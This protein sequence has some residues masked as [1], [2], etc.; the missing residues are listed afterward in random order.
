MIEK[1]VND[2]LDKQTAAAEKERLKQKM[3][4]AA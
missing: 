1:K 4:Q 2:W 3:K